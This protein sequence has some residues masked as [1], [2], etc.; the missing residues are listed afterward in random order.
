M[1]VNN[2][3]AILG[4]EKTT[5]KKFKPYNTIGKEEIDAVT[6]VMKTGV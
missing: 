4:G 6:E 3:L 2:K 5:N 1:I